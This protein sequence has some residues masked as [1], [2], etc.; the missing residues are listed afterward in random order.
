MTNPP[1]HLSL[2]PN[3]FLLYVGDGAESIESE[4]YLACWQDSDSLLIAD[5]AN[6]DHLQVLRTE[7]DLYVYLGSETLKNGTYLSDLA[8]GD[9]DHTR[10]NGIFVRFSKVDQTVWIHSDFLGTESVYYI[11]TNFG[12]FVSNRLDALA[13]V[14]HPEADPA[15]VYQY[16]LG[17]F[18]VAGRTMLRQVQQSRPASSVKYSIASGQLRTI[19]YNSWAK[20][21]PSEAPNLEAITFKWHQVLAGMPEHTLMLSAGW[22]SRL[23]LL[24]PRV[25]A[26]YTHGD[27]ESREVR[28]AF[29]LACTKALPMTFA[30]LDATD[31]SAE[32]LCRMNHELGHAFFPHWY[33]AAR[34]TAGVGPSLL[35]AGLFVEHF[36]GHYG[37]NSL[38]GGAEKLKNLAASMITPGVFDRLSAPDALEFLVPLLSRGFQSQPWFLG[39]DWSDFFGEAQSIYEADVADTLQG[40]SSHGTEGAQ[41]LCE[42]FRLEH[43]GRQY[44]AKQTKCALPFNGYYHPYGDSEFSNM[45][46]QIP[47]RNRVNYKLSRGVVAASDKSL[48]QFPMAATLVKAKHPILIQEG[49]RLT[50]I[51]MEKIDLIRKGGKTLNLGWNNFQF[52]NRSDAFH[53]YV[54]TLAHPIWSK[55]AMHQFVDKFTYANESAFSLLDMFS[56]ILTTDYVLTAAT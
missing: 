36:S 17:A 15:G 23:I 39:A 52:L 24:G 26:T 7:T 20:S 56:K 13:A 29:E 25:T 19:S 16:L 28:L 42:R 11:Q 14:A 41:E 10:H 30:P 32:H 8:S 43:S 21:G 48:L 1:L 33:R 18:T 3:S 45:V 27:L 37:I 53:D 40:Y 47:Y 22:D 35:T 49:S 44:F 55:S 6:K 4:S 54:D 46:V 38:S 34:Y 31:Y 12:F 5:F 51:A 2:K 50:R 9:W